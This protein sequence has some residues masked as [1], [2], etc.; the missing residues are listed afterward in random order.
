MEAFSCEL[1]KL[2]KLVRC[3]GICK[4]TCETIMEDYVWSEWLYCSL[5]L[6]YFICPRKLTLY[7]G[8]GNS[9]GLS[10]CYLFL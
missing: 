5:I 7:N 9:L 10:K 3:L 6:F 4:K 1:L 8:R 2:G